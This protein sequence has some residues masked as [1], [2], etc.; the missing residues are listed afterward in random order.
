[1]IAGFVLFRLFDHTKPWPARLAEQR[2]PI[3]FS[4]MF[5]DVVAGLW[6]AALLVGARMIGWL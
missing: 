3:G 6:A 1:L 2:L 5:D 4:V